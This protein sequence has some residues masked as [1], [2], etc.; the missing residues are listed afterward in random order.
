MSNINITQKCCAT[1]QFYGNEKREVKNNR[2]EFENGNHICKI[3]GRGNAIQSSMNPPCAKYQQ[4]KQ[5]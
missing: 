5:R 3:N 4:A 1:C 2:V